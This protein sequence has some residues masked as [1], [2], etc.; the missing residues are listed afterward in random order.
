MNGTL[1]SVKGWRHS[2]EE[3]QAAD[4]DGGDPSLEEWPLAQ[5]ICNQAVAQIRRDHPSIDPGGLLH[6]ALD[7]MTSPDGSE[8]SEAEEF[9]LREFL[10]VLRAVE[11][12]TSSDFGELCHEYASG[13]GV[14][15]HLLN[16]MFRGM[17]SE[18]YA[19][20]YLDYAVGEGSD[21]REDPAGG[22]LYWFNVNQI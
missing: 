22:T 10:S 15:E 13:Q 1:F 14:P 12:S 9:C 2:L 8:P 17:S 3:A 16:F 19:A 20:W 6:A 18:D 7:M 11:G 5:A 4:L 21:Y